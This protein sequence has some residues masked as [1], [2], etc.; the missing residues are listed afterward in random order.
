MIANRDSK[1]P[2]K[3]TDD[4]ARR[5]TTR[6]RLLIDYAQSLPEIQKENIGAYGMSLERLK[7][8]RVKLIVPKI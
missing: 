1:R 8:T 6:F 7:F 4:W 3:K 5:V 2:F